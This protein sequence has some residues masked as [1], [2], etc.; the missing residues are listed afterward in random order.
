[1]STRRQ[2]LR[3]FLSTAVLPLA[4]RLSLANEQTLSNSI[5]HS[6][7]A[8]NNFLTKHQL[9]DGSW[10]SQIYGPFKDGQSLT[11]LIAATL[12][13]LHHRTDCQ[14]AWSRATNY[15][16]AVA[17]T[18]QATTNPELTYPA[19]TAA[20]AI[21]AMAN[22]SEFNTARDNWLH[23]LRSLQ[24]T[25][26]HG[27]QPS[28]N[29][30]GGWGY[31]SAGLQPINGIPATPLA[32]PNL[33]ATAFALESLRSAGVQTCDPAIQKALTFV[34]RCQNWSDHPTQQDKHFDD[35]G[36]RFLLDDPQRNKAGKLGTDAAGKPRYASYGSATADG[37]RSLIACGLPADHPR[38]LAAQNWLHNHFSA[39]DHPGSYAPNREH[40][41]PTLY[42]Y[43]CYSASRALAFDRAFA[44]KLEALA[45][46]LISLQRP[47][48]SWL[49]PAVDVR[50]DDPLVAT[51]LAI[52]ALLACSQGTFIG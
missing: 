8:A 44:A 24:L 21:L 50:E 13:P 28:D 40:L 11:S 23:Y 36:F 18:E 41:R 15:L 14:P 7:T 43:Y 17:P 2:F 30:H 33:S 49:N 26:Q 31:A 16:A 32:V 4:L 3:S 12:A 6:L 34:N 38:R 35:G 5:A 37:L 19:Y 51:P 47:D 46:N 45:T 22:H 42:Y 25:E 20:G 9:P 39:T 10:R 52:Q 1:M 48:G 27:W 29:S